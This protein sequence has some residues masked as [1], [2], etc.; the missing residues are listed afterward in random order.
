MWE[1]VCDDFWGST[2]ARV[3]CQQLG[4]PGEGAT[5]LTSGFVNRCEQCVGNWDGIWLDNVRCAGT[6]ARLID[7]PARPIGEHNC[8]HRDDA[9]VKCVPI[10]GEFIVCIRLVP[11]E[12]WLSDLFNRH[13]RQPIL[14]SYLH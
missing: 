7:C 12:G 1:T 11:K 5:A 2:D 13:R 6:E 9:G 14:R 8:V 4:F 10:T 3:A